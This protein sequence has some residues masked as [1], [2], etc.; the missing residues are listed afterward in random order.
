MEIE[1]QMDVYRGEGESANQ[2]AEKIRK[3]AAAYY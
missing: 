1:F 2:T 3:H